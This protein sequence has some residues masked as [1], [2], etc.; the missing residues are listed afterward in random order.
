M[1]VRFAKSSSNFQSLSLKVSCTRRCLCRIGRLTQENRKIFPYQP[2]SIAFAGRDDIYLKRHSSASTT[3]ITVTIAGLIG[4]RQHVH[5][6][7]LHQRIYPQLHSECVNTGFC[8]THAPSS[9]SYLHPKSLCT[10]RKIA[11]PTVITGFSHSQNVMPS[12]SIAFLP[13]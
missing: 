10:L 5:Q 6:Q 2:N 8:N 1:S 7:H 3:V 13:R 11:F 12:T 9:M 4:Y